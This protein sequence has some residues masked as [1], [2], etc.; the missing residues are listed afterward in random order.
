[1]KDLNVY[2]IKEVFDYFIINPFTLSV[3]LLDRV[4]EY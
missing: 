4:M 1:M 2:S 3:T